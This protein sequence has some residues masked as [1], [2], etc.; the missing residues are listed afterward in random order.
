VSK[1]SKTN[2]DKYEWR[3]E[4][5]DTF[6]A[7]SDPYYK[8]AWFATELEAQ[9]QSKKYADKA[10]IGKGGFTK[11]YFEKRPKTN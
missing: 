5:F 10:A 3:F 8:S 11:V 4:V 9:K 7:S 1:K 2:H 6:D